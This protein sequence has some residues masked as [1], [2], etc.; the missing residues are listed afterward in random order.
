VFQGFAS[1][2]PVRVHKVYTNKLWD[3][4]G[5]QAARRAE[6]LVSVMRQAAPAIEGQDFTA[7]VENCGCNVSTSLWFRPL[8]HALEVV[9]QGC[10]WGEGTLQLSSVTGQHY[11]VKN[12]N[13]SQVLTNLCQVIVVAHAMRR[14]RC[15]APGPTSC[16]TW[17]KRLQFVARCA[18]PFV[19]SKH[20]ISNVRPVC[21]GV[22]EP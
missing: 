13:A 6:R 2:A 19:V 1:I 21:L 12:D 8:A 11:V 7:W 4:Y 16:T 17:C 15:S 18:P 3:K 10:C 5:L 20:S 9:A 22:S 14:T